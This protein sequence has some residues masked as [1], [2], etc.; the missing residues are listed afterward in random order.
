[1]LHSDTSEFLN[2]AVEDVCGDLKRTMGQLVGELKAIANDLPAS[3]A[4]D[5]KSESPA[6]EAPRCCCVPNVLLCT[7]LQY[8]AT[9]ARGWCLCQLNVGLERAISGPHSEGV[10]TAL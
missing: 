1:M 3:G 9:A 6:G 2:A 10:H 5:P 7:P 4:D 8:L